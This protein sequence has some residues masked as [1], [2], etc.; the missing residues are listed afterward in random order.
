MTVDELE[1]LVM[2]VWARC[3]CRNSILIFDSWKDYFKYLNKIKDWYK[4]VECGRSSSM[5]NLV[6]GYYP[7]GSVVIWDCEKV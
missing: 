3:E 7:L 2:G 1:F 4:C 5:S 6:H